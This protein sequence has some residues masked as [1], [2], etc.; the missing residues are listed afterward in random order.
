[1]TPRQARFVEEY[2][3]DLNGT[4][5]AIRAGYSEKTANEQATRLLAKAH[6]QEAVQ[7]GQ[8]ERSARTGVTAD[9]V[10][11]ELARIAF[12]DPRKVMMWGPGGVVLRESSELSDDDAA[13]VAEVSE[14]RSE[15]GGSI[16]AKLWSKPDALEKL[17]RH[18]G[19]YAA[20]KQQL[21]H[22]GP[23]GGPIRAQID[24][25]L[26]PDE[27]YRKMLGKDG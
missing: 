20:E 17:A 12:A 24:A 15:N 5:A 3:V 10:I 23:G 1:M 26:T 18:L 9:R 19:L 2:L 13:I 6:I 11:Q 14:T 8:R 27:A 7:A 21:E 16:K 22:S 4:Q 25:T